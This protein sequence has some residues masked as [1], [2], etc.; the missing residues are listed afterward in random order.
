MLTCDA[1]HVPLV[2]Q[3][4]QSLCAVQRNS[5]S[6]EPVDQA[7]GKLPHADVA[8]TC[9]GDGANFAL[10]LLLCILQDVA[11]DWRDE[12]EQKAG[13]RESQVPRGTRGALG[14]R[15]QQRARALPLRQKSR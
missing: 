10:L 9:Q 3:Q 4:K 1:L 8:V 13:S 11:Q 7:K 15:L 12:R 14:A 5:G 6:L 2:S